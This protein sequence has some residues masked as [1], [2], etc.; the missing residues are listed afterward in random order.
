MT[1]ARKPNEYLKVKIQTA[2][3]SE[4]LLLLLDGAIRFTV[5]AR[6]Y[7]EQGSLEEKNRLILRAQNIV[8]ELIQALDQRIGEELYGRLVGLYRFCYE[9][10]LRANLKNDVAA[11]DEALR[12]LEH[13]RETWRMAVKKAREERGDAAPPAAGERHALCL[14]G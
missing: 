2:N 8:L 4:L 10:L 3:P 14:E 7:I 5:Q 6:R 11:A 1:D 13:L 12:I 9:R